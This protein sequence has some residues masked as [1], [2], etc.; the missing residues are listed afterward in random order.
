[1]LLF[2]AML[3]S[4][5]QH[6]LHFYTPWKRQNTKGFLT[7]LVGIEMEHYQRVLESKNVNGNV[8]TKFVNIELA[9]T[10]RVADEFSLR[11]KKKRNFKKHEIMI[12]CDLAG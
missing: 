12:V 2:I 10:T 5:V 8:Y 7:F 9:F 11:K 4:S 6:L 1:M 3:S